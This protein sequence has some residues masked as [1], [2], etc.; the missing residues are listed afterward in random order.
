MDSMLEKLDHSGDVGPNR[1]LRPL[2]LLQKKAGPQ[3]ENLASAEGETKTSACTKKDDATWHRK[4]RRSFNMA[5]RQC[6]PKCA[7]R[8]SCVSDCMERAEGYTK[9]CAEVRRQDQL[10]V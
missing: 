2:S 6:A 4:G 9:L 10:R 7:G 1:Q 5:M 3:L 8:T